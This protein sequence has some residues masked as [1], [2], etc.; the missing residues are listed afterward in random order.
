MSLWPT[1]DGKMN[2]KL[3]DPIYVKPRQCINLK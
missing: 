1:Y 3:K 2:N